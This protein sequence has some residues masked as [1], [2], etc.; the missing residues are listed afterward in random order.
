MIYVVRGLKSIQSIIVSIIVLKT[1]CYLE[2][3]LKVK[4]C[5]YQLSRLYLDQLIIGINLI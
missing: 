3:L 5:F 1:N 4:S 2:V